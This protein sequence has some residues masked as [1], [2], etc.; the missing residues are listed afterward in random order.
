MKKGQSMTKRNIVDNLMNYRI[1]INTNI[2][3]VNHGYHHF[4]LK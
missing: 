2:N 3:V 4:D 1:H